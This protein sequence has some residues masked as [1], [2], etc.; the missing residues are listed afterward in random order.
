MDQASPSNGFVGPSSPLELLIAEIWQEA[1]GI[2][3]VSI[4]DNFFDLGGHSLLSAEVIA[5]IQQKTKIRVNPADVMRQT[6]GQLAT[7]CEMRLQELSEAQ[8]VASQNIIQKF[9]KS[10]KKMAS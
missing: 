10:I 8:P 2:E 3:R 7:T 9:F 1:L 5:K 4:Y 6:L